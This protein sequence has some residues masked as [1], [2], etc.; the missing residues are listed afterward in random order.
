M[1]VVVDDAV[2]GRMIVVQFLRRLGIKQE[3]LV[4]ELFR[5]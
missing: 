2:L 1:A 5:S 3:V 4:Q